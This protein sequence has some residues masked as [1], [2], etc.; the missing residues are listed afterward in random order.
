MPQTSNGRRRYGHK[1]RPPETGPSNEGR[2]TRCGEGESVG[3]AASDAEDKT[4]DQVATGEGS[5][6]GHGSRS[7]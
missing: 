1:Y 5:F 6:G 7:E 2:A 4:R 3:V